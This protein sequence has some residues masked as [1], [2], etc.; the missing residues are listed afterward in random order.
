MHIGENILGRFE[1]D[2]YI[3]LP[4]ILTLEQLERYRA[5]TDRITKLRFSINR[6]QGA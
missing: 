4:G 6:N 5:I 3:L 1:K 2:G